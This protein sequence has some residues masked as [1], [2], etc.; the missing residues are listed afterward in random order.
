MCGANCTSDGGQSESANVAIRLV[1]SSA[2]RVAKTT[3]HDGRI[4]ISDNLYEVR[5]T[6]TVKGRRLAGQQVGCHSLALTSLVTAFRHLSFL[7]LLLHIGVRFER[8]DEE[9]EISPPSKASM[10]SKSFTIRSLIEPDKPDDR[11]KT[12]TLL[13]YRQTHFVLAVAQVKAISK[14]LK[15]AHAHFYSKPM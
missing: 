9:T 11:R 14:R 1:N 2:M 7:R 5:S 10:A 4:G 12:G 15:A 3:L 13:A 6:W 8:P